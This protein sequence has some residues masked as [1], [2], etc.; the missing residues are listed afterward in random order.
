MDYIVHLKDI[1]EFTKR[2][3]ITSFIEDASEVQGIG[4]PRWFRGKESARQRRRPGLIP[5]PG[6]S[7]MP[8]GG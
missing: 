3:S 2:P 8:Q 4:L 1:T 7:H 5:N 6:R